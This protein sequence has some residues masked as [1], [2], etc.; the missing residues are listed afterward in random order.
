MS[1]ITTELAL[2]TAVDT[3]DTADYLTLNLANS[4]RTVDALFNNV[5]GHTHASA[6]QGGPIAASSVR[7]PM[8]I[9]DWFRSTG[10]TTAYASSG[11]GM[12]MFWS[13]TA[14]VLQA[15]NAA[16][17]GFAPVQLYG[18]T[19]TLGINGGS[20][21]AIAGDGT[22]TTG[23]SLVDNGNLTVAGGT[24]LQ[25]VTINGSL[26]VGGTANIT[27]TIT[28]NTI[29]AQTING[30]ALGITGLATITSNATVGGVLNVNGGGLYLAANN[31]CYIGRIGADSLG[32]PG[33]LYIGHSN[34]TYFQRSAAGAI[35]VNNRLRFTVDSG[36]GPA[37]I[38]WPGGASV[39]NGT[40]VSRSGAVVYL[41]AH[42]FVFFD[43]ECGHTMTCQNLVQTSD[44][45]LKSNMVIVPDVD[46][47]TRV[48]NT[49][50]EVKAY[51]LTP[52]PGEPS[53]PNPTPT[54]IGFDATQ[55]YAVA[56]EFAALNDQGQPV[57]VTYSNMAAMLWGALRS[58]D[59]RCV[60]KGI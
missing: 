29:S 5:T 52:P 54:D 34:D 15:R 50:L 30:T 2:S 55:V 41:S 27:G 26:A 22:V 35:M 18:S 46:C 24:V 56:P 33:T 21:L 10:H 14:G 58:L 38:D 4:L 32:M 42:A 28:C 44:P 11:V 59:A 7:G 25:G 9:A 31:D 40:S 13:G 49:G 23:S 51:Q 8:D 43:L 48:R 47:M 19:I 20:H 60:A 39:A 57:G 53:G 3:D 6:H 17:A 12:E 36:G 37:Q 45:N 1:G 16:T